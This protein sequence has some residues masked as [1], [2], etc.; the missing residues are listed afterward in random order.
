MSRS[1][2]VDAVFGSYRLLQQVGEGG[3]GRVF[4][5]E[6]TQLGRQVAIKILRSE[7]AGNVEAVKRFFSEARAVNLIN[8]EN[9]IE[10]SDFVANDHG[11]SYY[12]MELLKGTDL[13]RLLDGE[14]ILP[15]PRAVDIALQI[16]RGI[17]A[18]HAVGIIHRDLKPENVYL[19]ERNG[20]QDFVKLL[21]FGVAKLLN[22]GE[23][24]IS[25]YKTNAGIIV[26][27]PDYMSPEQGAGKKF[28]HRT[29][30]YSLGV[31]LFEMVTGQ[32]PFRAESFGEVL[33]QH[34]TVPPPR[35]STLR[36]IP[37][38][39]PP[40]FER[41]ILSCLAK[42]PEGRPAD[43]TEV[44]QILE[45]IA[46]GDSGHEFSLQEKTAIRSGHRR[47]GPRV[48]WLTV[49]CLAAV[50]AGSW[51]WLRP[52]A[53]LAPAPAQAAPPPARVAEH[54]PP[55]AIPAR[56]ILR[57]QSEPAGAEVFVEGAT[58]PLGVTPFSVALPLSSQVA[59]FEFRLQGHRAERRQ[60]PVLD[61]N[62][63]EATLAAELPVAAAPAG[64]SPRP[65]PRHRAQRL[66]RGSV[67]NPFK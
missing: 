8:H 66:D 35:P 9:I 47:R 13:R 50:G 43:M 67:L 15:L 5:A 26:G 29:D 55:A 38:S 37:H 40:L 18:A 27:T 14:Q 32:R 54:A 30:I 16:A 7:Y 60:V 44:Q 42:E 22:S 31:V 19:I 33:I 10:I 24:Q 39:L 65:Q 25:T 64:A 48:A 58:E 49:A 61:G 45:A 34:M 46:R 3:M 23:H 1:V 41:L 53:T 63:V 56:A 36:A 57:F 11:H 62:R 12:I 17:T 51:L 4:V 59:T 21:D 28:D 52:P 20:R 6:H 2:Q